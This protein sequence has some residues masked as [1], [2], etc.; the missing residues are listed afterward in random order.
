MPKRLLMREPRL[1]RSLLI[2]PGNRPERLVKAA[3]L[4]ADALVLDLEDGVPGPEK[5][6]ARRAVAAF[7]D[8]VDCGPRERCVR[9]NA[10]GSTELAADLAALPFGRFDSIM[11]PKVERP[12]ALAGLEGALRSYE[13]AR[14]AP[15]DLIVSIETPR[16]VLDALA[17]ADASPR[18]S[19]LFFGSGDYCA[20]LG[21]PVTEG[22]LR[23]PRA[24]VAA[25]A[26]AAGLQAIDAAFFAAVKDPVATRE[27][28]LWARE[29]GY[30][31]KLVFHPAQ[32]AVVNEA[33]SPTADELEWAEKVLSTYRAAE[34]AGTGT[35]V[36]DGT[37][38][39]IDIVVLA[40]RLLRRAHQI[41]DRTAPMHEREGER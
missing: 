35:A 12:A 38:V 24:A 11:V 9:V 5:D 10:V 29:L 39:A 32:V 22:A 25:A 26:A 19:A 16:G 36:V 18:S 7:L 30:S 40:K 41:A 34:Q 37:F 3:T 20:A 33:F 17:V 8:S 13:G 2:T 31:G 6:A 1:R 28:A 14:V 21:A 15:V 4:S 23:F 27:D